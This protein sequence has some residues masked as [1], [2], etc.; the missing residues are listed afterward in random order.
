MSA[1][2]YVD[3]VKC[4]AGHRF[5]VTTRRIGTAGRTVRTYCQLC[6]KAYQ[7]KAGSVP[8]PKESK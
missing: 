8:A 5:S 4:P 6:R 3:K 7:I 1:K 2:T